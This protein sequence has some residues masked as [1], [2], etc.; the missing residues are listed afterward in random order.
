M[1]TTRR[2]SLTIAGA[3]Y[4]EWTAV[5]VTRTLDEIS[6]SFSLELRDGARS[7]ASWPF[8]SLASLAASVDLWSEVSVA[9]DG[10]PVLVGWIDEI[11]PEA[12]DG[13]V[14]LSVTGRDKSGDLVDGAATV[15]GPAEYRKMTV[16]EAAK[17]IAEPYGITVKA[18]ADVGDP[19]DR[20]AIDPGETAMSAI[21]K[22]ARQRALVVTSD[23]VGGLVLTQT[24]KQRAPGVLVFPGNVVESAGSF[25]A[26]ERHSEYVV[27]GQAEKAAGGRSQT[28]Y[29]DST[30][31][32]LTADQSSRSE[33]QAAREEAGVAISGRAKDPD[34][35]RYRP[36]VSLGRTQLDAKSAQ[37]QADWMMRTTRGRAELIEHRVRG[38]GVGG[39]LW[40]PNTLV[41]VDDSYLAVHRDMLIAGVTYRF[42]EGGPYT[43]LRLAGPE[44]YDLEPD[45]DRRQNH[46]RGG[47]AKSAGKSKGA[48]KAL[49]STAEP[50]SGS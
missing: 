28:A 17:K 32:P 30:A 33:K 49:D 22:L 7:V 11:A 21:E 23:G 18:D 13:E 16:L 37:K 48:T 25:R 26:Q 34:V 24:G 3:V 44:A 36:I 39:T 5:E 8:A 35:K 46:K 15:D 31:E 14:R 42:D 1:I 29:L 10:Q 9:I 47:A 27:K 12:R 4:D 20:V 2:V 43:R 50:L 40:R 41:L 45:S 19:F 38:F 6:A